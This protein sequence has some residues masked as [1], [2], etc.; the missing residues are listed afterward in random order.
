[1]A[2]YSFP[3]ED[4]AWDR[5]D[6]QAALIRGGNG[7]K[8]FVRQ[9]APNQCLINGSFSCPLGGLTPRVPH[10]PQMQDSPRTSFSLEMF[11]AGLTHY[12]RAPLGV[13]FDRSHLDLQT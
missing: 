12:K 13:G 10:L 1:M 6:I 4:A 7:L 8:F 11:R 2:T 5:E 9:Y 3:P